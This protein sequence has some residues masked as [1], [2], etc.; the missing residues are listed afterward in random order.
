MLVEAQLTDTSSA[1]PETA[2]HAV[3]PVLLLVL[4]AIVVWMGA[5]GARRRRARRLAGRETDI[6]PPTSPDRP[7]D[8]QA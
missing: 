3:S 5:I 1:Q 4:L 6:T 8:G 7:F 2:R